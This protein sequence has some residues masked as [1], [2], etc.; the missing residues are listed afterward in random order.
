MATTI[1]QLELEVQS[2]S[3]SAVSGIDALAASLGKLK[4]ATK[5]GMGL[6]RVANQLRNLNTALGGLDS[7]NISKIDALT[8]SL[9][10]LQSLGNLKLSSSIANQ[11]TNIGTAAGTLANVDLSSIGNMAQA[12]QPLNSIS[13]G[14]LGS[15]ASALNRLPKVA[16]TLNGIDWTKFTSQIQQMTNALTPLTNQ[17]NTVSA[18]YNQL[19]SNLRKTVSATNAITNANN[20]A[21]NSY[22]NL[23]AKAMMAVNAMRRG[24]TMVAG[25]ITKSN[26]Y[27]EDLNLFNASMGQYAEEAQKYAEQVGELMGID[28]GEFMRN[29]GTFNTIISG[30]GVASDKAYLMSKNLTQLGYDISSFFN[31]SFEDAMQK[32][33]SGISGELEPMRRL[34]YDLSVARLQEEALALGITKK[35]SAMTQAEKSQ[36]RYYAIMT[37]VTTAQGD[38]ARTLDAPAN[39]LRVLQAQIT[40]CARALGNIFI[41]AL[42]A[43]LPYVTALAK[44]VRYL[45]D[46]IARLVGFK[47]PE[48][49]YSSLDGISGSAADASDA[50]ADANATATKLK[51]TI[52]GFDELN[53]LKKDTSYSS[54]GYGGNDLG[55]DLPSYDFIGDAVSSKIDDVIQKLKDWL[56]LTDDINNLNDLLHTKLGR[57]LTTVGAIAAGLAAWKIATGVMKALDALEKL[58]NSPL[59]TGYTIALGI[60]LLVTG[61]TLEWAGIIDAIKNELNKMNFAQIVSGALLT[62]GGGAILGKG[63]AQWI[64]TSFANSAVTTVLKA[65]AN[66]LGLSTATAAGSAIGA[67]VAAIIA[68]LPAYFTGIYD[69]CHNGLNWLNGLLIPIGSTLAGTGIA[70]ILAAAGTAIAPGIGT[71]IGLAVGLVTDGIILIVQKWDVIS[72]WFSEKWAA[73]QGWWSGTASPFLQGI[74]T[75]IGEV[76]ESVRSWFVDK[77]T[78]VTDFMSTVPEKIGSAMESVRS[79][80]ID[81]WTAVTDYMNTVPEKIGTVV[82]AVGQWFSELPGKIGYGL[83]FAAGKVASWALDVW[84]VMT[85]NVPQIISAVGQWFSELPGNV[86][87]WLSTTLHNVAEWGTNLLHEASTAASNACHAVAEFFKELPRNI[88]TVFSNILKTASEWGAN[89]LKSFTST[90]LP[91]ITAV[92]QW[93]GEL[94]SKVLTALSTALKTVAQWGADLK[95]KVKEVVPPVIESIRGFF[96]ELPGKLKALGKDIWNGFV[97]GLTAAW[98]TVAQ[99]LKKFVGGFVQG[100]KDGLGIHSPST[101]MS[102]IGQMCVAGLKNGLANIGTVFTSVFSTIKNWLGSFGKNMF[103]WGS[104]MMGNLVNGINSGLRSLQQKV[105]SAANTI[106]SYLHFSQPDVGPLADF[107]SWMPDMMS[108]LA[109][110]IAR[111]EDKVRKQVAKLANT[112]NLEPTMQAN[113]SAYSAAPAVSNGESSDGLVSAIYNAVSSAIAGQSSGEDA[114]TP[115]IINLGNE[116]IASFL[117]KQNKRVALISGGKA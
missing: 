59:A 40:Q 43:V 60:S 98:T 2:N 5:G 74:A 13:A 25:W 110:G 72:A 97:Q 53:V 42:N 9:T 73:V 81:K 101:V 92:G 107:N 20:S 109:E 10:K 70:T 99:A 46:N 90:V 117:V 24:V 29:Q 56:G 31:I 7:G 55:I 108:Q 38:M 61:I 88:M 71:L 63:V 33:Q 6:T 104:E 15:A 8:N 103:T 34:G 47:L 28:P 100:F 50:L 35:V 21:S 114:G 41:P 83:G 16:Q 115:I 17:L 87:T 12:L 48:V 58:R 95:A 36:L 27:I 102:N 116:Q 94:P 89:L 77:W 82:D 18:A 62:V 93:F 113:V 37:Q 91:A 45:A 14:G 52:M 54:S 11:I 65:A 19:P 76:L 64:T 111:D 112:M 32:L 3:T 22:V 39:Q 85:E 84:N 1:E 69:A 4:D 23:Y 79:W 30:F 51:R 96:A 44:G 57:I 86:M 80:V 68:G 75:S 105:A 49:D 66:N 67:G 26:Q 106:R 78:A